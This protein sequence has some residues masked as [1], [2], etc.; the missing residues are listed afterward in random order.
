MQRIVC[1][2]LKN[3]SRDFV[4]ASTRGGS[5]RAG[6]HLLHP[7]RTRRRLYTDVGAP[8]VSHTPPVPPVELIARLPH[9]YPTL[10]ECLERDTHKKSGQR[11]ISLYHYYIF[12][13]FHSFHKVYQTKSDTPAP[14]PP[15]VTALK[16]TEVSAAFVLISTTHQLMRMARRKRREK[17]S[18]KRGRVG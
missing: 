10:R 14:H 5:R 12:F 4:F 3:L 17:D 1:V 8:T 13:S 11:S 2:C 9:I 16:R 18:V 15:D 6:K 7:C